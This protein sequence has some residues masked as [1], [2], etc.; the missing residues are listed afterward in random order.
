[1]NTMLIVDHR[2]YTIR[3]RKMNDFLEVFESLAMPVLRETLGNPLGF[4]TSFVGPQ[5]QFV[6]LWGYE[7]LAEYERRS[8]LRDT[9]PGFAA[10]LTASEP[11]IVSQETRL[12]RATVMP[13]PKA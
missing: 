5:N 13:T 11:F 4:Y 7:S 6:H 8:R 12:I 3:L 10:Y 2:I 9:H 1:M